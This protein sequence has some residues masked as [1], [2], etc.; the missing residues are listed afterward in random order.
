M[1][2]DVITIGNIANGIALLVFGILSGIGLYMGRKQQ[3]S[4]GRPAPQGD[5]VEIAGALIDGQQARALTAAL[6]R[7]TEAVT[8]AGV[9]VDDACREI[10]HLTDELIRSQ[11]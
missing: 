10:R 3:S 7:N 11:K 8:R 9:H 6:D 4:A 2:G 5:T 1:P